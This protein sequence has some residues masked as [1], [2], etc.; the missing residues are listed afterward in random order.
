MSYICKYCKRDIFMN[1]TIHWLEFP[2]DE[3][4]QYIENTTHNKD[5]A[6]TV[7][8]QPSPKSDK[9]DFAQS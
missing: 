5:C 2:C 8:E 6:V 4:L 9:S 3:Y 1:V 7:D